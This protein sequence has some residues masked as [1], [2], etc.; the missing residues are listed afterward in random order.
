MKCLPHAFTEQGVAMLATVLRT[1]IAVETSIKIMRSFVEMRK[2]SSNSCVLAN[3]ESRLINLE[4]AFEH[5]IDNEPNKILFNGQFYDSYSILLDILKKSSF[6]IIII[7]NYSWKELFDILKTINK[8]IIVVSKNLD[9][10]LVSKYKQ[11][12]NN[13]TF[14]NNFHCL[15]C[16]F[17]DLLV[18]SR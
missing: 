17:C 1:N 9:N 2:Y 8:N 12:H 16:L 18:H 7:D 6:E 15:A 4:Q 3:H 14:I 5:F 11:Q 10:T 13:I